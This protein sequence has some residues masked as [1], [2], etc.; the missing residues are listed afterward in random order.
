MAGEIASAE[1]LYI[2]AAV[3]WLV[4]VLIVV[5]RKLV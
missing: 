4:A 1:A 2:A 3:L 5:A